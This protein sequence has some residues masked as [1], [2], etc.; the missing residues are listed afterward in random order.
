MAVN[1]Y[2]LTFA[3]TGDTNGKPS[4]K[5]LPTDIDTSTSLILPGKGRVNYGEFYDTNILQMLEHFA[6][7]KPPHQPTSGQVWYNTKDYNLRLFMGVNPLKP[8]EYILNGDTN[9]DSYTGLNEINKNN[10]NQGWAYLMHMTGLE[11]MYPYNGQLYFNMTEHKLKTWY[12]KWEN[13]AYESW[14]TNKFVDVTG[15]TMTGVL[16]MSSQNISD[17][18]DPVLDQDAATKKWSTDSFVNVIGD[19]MSGV[20]YMGSNFISDLKDPV[21]AQDAVTKKYFDDELIKVKYIDWSSYFDTRTVP[22]NNAVNDHPGTD[23][24]GHKYWDTLFRRN[25]ILEVNNIY[26]RNIS[27]DIKDK[28]KCVFAKMLD[29]T[30]GSTTDLS[31]L[32]F[33]PWVEERDKAVALFY[34]VQPF[35]KPVTV[36]LIQT[37]NYSSTVGPGGILGVNQHINLNNYLM[38]VMRQEMGNPTFTI[39]DNEFGQKYSIVDQTLPP[40]T[41][42]AKQRGS[43]PSIPLITGFNHELPLSET[44]PNTKLMLNHFDIVWWISVAGSA[45]PGPTGFTGKT[46]N[47]FYIEKSDKT[48]ND[49]TQTWTFSVTIKDTVYGNNT[50]VV[51]WDRLYSIIDGNVDNLSNEQFVSGG[52][53]PPY[54]RIM[55]RLYVNW[56]YNNNDIRNLINYAK[57]GRTEDYGRGAISASEPNSRLTYLNGLIYVVSGNYGNSAYGTSGWTTYLNWASYAA[58]LSFGITTSNFDPKT[59]GLDFNANITSGTIGYS[60]FPSNLLINKSTVPITFNIY[61]IYGTNPNNGKLE[62]ILDISTFTDACGW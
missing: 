28:F 51:S 7:A 48:R 5:I 9:L 21:L 3:S 60:Y 61:P 30:L 58:G 40:V 57:Q 37:T 35:K 11:P 44:Y 26:W 59:G 23:K 29:F 31:T 33:K 38:L 1:Y 24:T 34:G 17:L 52:T 41:T 49:A 18:A 12:T 62:N 19:T 16:H 36:D 13:V 43:I 45:Y 22:Y 42:D 25:G 54:V 15:D 55:A 14:A 46:D 4:I 6:K 8:A 53:P 20:L 27:D 39:H 50:F 56:Q 10:R 47:R 2:T 32:K